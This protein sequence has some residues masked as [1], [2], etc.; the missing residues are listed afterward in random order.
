MDKIV[1]IVDDSPTFRR[2]ASFN[3][4]SIQGFKSQL[5]ANDG[6]EGLEKMANNKVD[7]VLLDLNMP[8]M[9]GFEFLKAKRDKEEYKNIPV[10][11]LTTEGDEKNKS[12]AKELGAAGFLTKPFNSMQLRRALKEIFG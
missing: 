2:I 11:M 1:L 8:V 9:D 3:F 7:L 4:K 12:Q 5:E 10:I 6:K